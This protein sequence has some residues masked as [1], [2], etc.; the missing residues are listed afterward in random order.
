MQTYD[1]HKSVKRAYQRNTLLVV[2]FF[3]FLLSSNFIFRNNSKIKPMEP[4]TQFNQA[5]TTVTYIYSEYSS[6]SDEFVFAFSLPLSEVNALYEYQVIAKADKITNEDLPFDMKKIGQ[7]KYVVFL[8][9]LPRKWK[10]LSVQ[11]TAKDGEH[12]I[13]EGDGAFI[14]ERRAVKETDKKIAKDVE[15]Y[16]QFFVDTRV[17]TIEKTIKET[18]KEIQ[19]LKSNNDKIRAVNKQLKDSESQETGEELE[20]I[21]TKQQD[22]ESQIKMNDDAI[23]ELEIKIKDNEEKIEALKK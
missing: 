18:E 19:E 3:V 15:H 5:G 9:E 11:V 21:K 7:D 4:G 23:K 16:S 13:L 22:N 2:L 10:K 14:F 1:S 12:D 6:L 20:A 17:K 8:K